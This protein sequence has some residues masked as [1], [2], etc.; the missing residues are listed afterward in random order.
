[1]SGNSSSQGASGMNTPVL[2]GYTVTWDDDRRQW[3][4]SSNTDDTVLYGV[5]Q[6]ELEL[7]RK[8]LV[9]R[10][11]DDLN[12]MIREAPGRGYSPPKP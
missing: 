4:A 3:A 10:L 1:M 5:D 12:Q 2:P 7:A 6:Q 11:A 8:R 9:T